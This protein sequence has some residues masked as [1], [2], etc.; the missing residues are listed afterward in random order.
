MFIA[1][2]PYK[3]ADDR[4]KIAVLDTT[5]CTVE[6]V[7][8]DY[9]VKNKFPLSNF[10]YEERCALYVSPLVKLKCPQTDFVVLLNGRLRVG[11]MCVD[12]KFVVTG[13]IYI[14]GHTYKEQGIDNMSGAY[15]ILYPFL[16]NDML[17]IRL[18]YTSKVM[19]SYYTVVLRYPTGE[20]IHYWSGDYS[21]TDD[22]V[23][24]IRQDIT[25]GGI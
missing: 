2:V 20:V 8:T 19:N 1:V 4:S 16:I 17:Y 13:G 5:D 12:C 10:V 22:R 14:N 7:S 9:I 18:R 11:Y 24:A 3:D 23:F 25:L 6:F 15:H 21:I